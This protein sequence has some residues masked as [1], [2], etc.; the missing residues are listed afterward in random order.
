MAEKLVDGEGKEVKKGRGAKAKVKEVQPKRIQEDAGDPSGADVGAK[1]QHPDAEAQ[2]KA[3]S[4]QG[5]IDS[6]VPEGHY[7]KQERVRKERLDKEA[8]DERKGDA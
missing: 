1:Y 6:V 4:V 8:A 2:A 5:S 7:A 3:E